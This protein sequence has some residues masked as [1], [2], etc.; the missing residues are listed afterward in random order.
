MGNWSITHFK[1][2]KMTLL[3]SNC[4]SFKAEWSVEPS[5]SEE[6]HRSATQVGGALCCPSL[7]LCT[8]YFPTPVM[9]PHVVVLPWPFLLSLSLTPCHIFCPYLYPILFFFY[10]HP[11][12]SQFTFPFLFLSHIVI[13]LFIPCQPLFHTLSCPLSCLEYLA[14]THVT[15]LLCVWGALSGQTPFPSHAQMCFCTRTLQANTHALH[16]P[17]PKRLAWANIRE[18]NCLGREGSSVLVHVDEQ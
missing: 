18:L 9:S 10:S 4:Y 8:P 17:G 6:E 13:C 7:L 11:P 15:Y 14:L 16:L 5:F 12:T 1:Q 3:G 2:F